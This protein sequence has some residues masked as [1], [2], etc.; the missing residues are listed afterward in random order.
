MRH[1]H[2]ST[3]KPKEQWAKVPVRLAS[4]GLSSLELRA[5]IALLSFADPRRPGKPV[6]AK[7]RTIANLIGLKG[8]RSSDNTVC[9][10]IHGLAAKGLLENR[11]RPGRGLSICLKPVLREH[12]STEAAT[13]TRTAL[14][15][16]REQHS[17]TDHTIEQTIQRVN[18][19]SAATARPDSDPLAESPRGDGNGT[20]PEADYP[21]M[22]EAQE[23]ATEFCG[24]SPDCFRRQR[25]SY[26]AMPAARIKA[27]V[28][29]Q[30][31]AKDKKP[32][33]NPDAYFTTAMWRESQ[34]KQRREKP[35]R[36]QTAEDFMGARGFV[37]S[38]RPAAAPLP[39]DDPAWGK[40]GEVEL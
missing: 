17:T 13:P 14:Q 21:T 5:M 12:H 34:P 24:I 1:G 2:D 10:A 29:R 40:T 4:A 22:I 36:V 37:A 6:W 16:P 33:Q 32:I 9:R 27:V 3:T 23:Q 18:Q 7:A 31:D 25:D 35:E 8:T 15:P 39:H 20:H 28:G 11:T 30:W 26:P 19:T 38:R